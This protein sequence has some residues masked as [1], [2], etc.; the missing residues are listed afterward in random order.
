[1]SQMN[2]SDLSQAVAHYNRSP[3]Q[4]F[5]ILLVVVQWVLG[6]YNVINTSAYVQ[7]TQTN[8]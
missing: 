5:S 6:R 7:D 2:L 8:L 3:V 1:M 4:H